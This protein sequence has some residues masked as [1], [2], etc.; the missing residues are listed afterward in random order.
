MKLMDKLG[1]SSIKNLF[2][3]RPEPEL[4]QNETVASQ[5]NVVLISA[6]A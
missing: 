4:I 3:T 1:G 5:Q 6:V 2:A